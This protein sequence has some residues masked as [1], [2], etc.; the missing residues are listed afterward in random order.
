MVECCISFRLADSSPRRGDPP[1]DIGIKG[2]SY[3]FFGD[4]T[5]SRGRWGGGGEGVPK[6]RSKNALTLPY[7]DVFNNFITVKKK[8]THI[9]R[10]GHTE[11]T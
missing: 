3:I 2:Y 6:I 4:L 10:K 9:F 8:F 11:H 7:T 5:I 1:A